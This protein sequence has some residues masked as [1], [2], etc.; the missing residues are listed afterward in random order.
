MISAINLATRRLGPVDCHAKNVPVVVIFD[1][2]ILDQHA[3]RDS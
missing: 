3:E 1:L 2:L